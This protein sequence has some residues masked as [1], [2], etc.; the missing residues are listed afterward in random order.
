MTSSLNIFYE[1]NERNIAKV[2]ATQESVA[3]INVVKV[4][5]YLNSLS[6]VAK[7]WLCA[8]YVLKLLKHV[9]IVPSPFFIFFV[10][11]V[12]IYSRGAHNW[13]S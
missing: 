12:W 7:I 6:W 9:L 2:L 11:I 8:N 5:T 13:S 10:L 1:G 4:R 3:L